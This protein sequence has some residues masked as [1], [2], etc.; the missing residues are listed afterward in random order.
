MDL[1]IIISCN[2]LAGLAVAHFVYN[3]QDKF[4]RHMFNK[5]STLEADEMQDTW[6]EHEKL[7]YFLIILFG[8]VF[9]FLILFGVLKKKFKK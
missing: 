9:M 1:L 6:F 7:I 2:F 8:Y 5:Y 4:W 3:V